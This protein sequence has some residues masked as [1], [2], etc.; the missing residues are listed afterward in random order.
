MQSSYQWNKHSFLRLY[1]V[2]LGYCQFPTSTCNFSTSG[3]EGNPWPCQSLPDFGTRVSFSGPV[4]GS[5]RLFLIK[6]TASKFSNRSLSKPGTGSLLDS[7]CV[8][9]QTS[10]WPSQATQQSGRTTGRSDYISKPPT[11]ANVVKGTTLKCGIWHVATL[12]DTFQSVV[13]GRQT[14]FFM[15]VNPSLGTFIPDCNSALVP[16]LA[17]CAVSF[18]TWDNV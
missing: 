17:D 9:T 7:N 5:M 6:G 12:G 2:I 15:E 14:T 13:S 3:A 4:R 10:K 11:I 18:N 8:C 1:I 16:G